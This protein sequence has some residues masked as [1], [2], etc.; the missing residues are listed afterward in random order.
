MTSGVLRDGG[1][2]DENVKEALDLCLACKGCKADCPVSVDMAT[3][4]AEF[5][6][7]YY[8]G[9]IRP[10]QAYA[11]GLIPVWARLAAKVP[12]VVNAW[13]SAPLT[14][15][16]SKLAA[17]VEPAR[18]APEFAAT[19]FREWFARHEPKHGGRE[20][21]LWVDT[22]TNHFTPRWGSRR[23]ASWRRP[24]AP[25]GSHRAACAVAGRYSTTGCSR[26][27]NAGCAA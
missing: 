5:L 8:Q 15:W 26:P 6:S 16:G 20:V 9:R 11:L 1:W 21:L 14:G 10:R 3:Y 18:P 13:M 27:R 25:C 17:G 7:H 22:F 12:G 19:T 4:K 23:S 2:R 24:A